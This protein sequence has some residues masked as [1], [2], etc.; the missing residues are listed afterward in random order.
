MI[1]FPNVSWNLPVL[2]YIRQYFNKQTRLKSGPFVFSFKPLWQFSS[3]PG[4]PVHF[5][6][7]Y[8]NKIY[9]YIQL[10]PGKLGYKRPGTLFAGWLRDYRG[11]DNY[12]R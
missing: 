4:V 5:Q 12:T 9:M 1:Q 6:R 11:S 3:G 7:W 2:H 10:G 8:P